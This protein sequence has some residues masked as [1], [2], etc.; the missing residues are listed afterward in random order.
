M[1]D[2]LPIFIDTNILL[3]IH[4]T[5]AER[6]GTVR[7][8]IATLNTRFAPVWI[9]RQVLREFA[10][11][12]TRE[13]PY[14]PAVPAPDV[15]QMMRPFETQYRIAD[16]TAGVT[17]SWYSLLETIPVGGKQ[18]HDA[19]IVAT[20]LSYQISHLFTLNMSDFGRYAHLI[21]LVSLDELLKAPGNAENETHP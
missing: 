1:T 5:S 18:V 7:A 3:R 21:T 2:A 10:S 15:I 16:E 4:V 11:V 17:S 20:M 14:A 12:L 6:S 19:N 9:S 13:Q 8:A